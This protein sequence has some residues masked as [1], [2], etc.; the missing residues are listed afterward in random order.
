MALRSTH[1]V[2]EMITRNLSEGEGRLARKA[3]LTAIRES[4][5]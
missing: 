5:V 4:M 3:D 2:T 1:H